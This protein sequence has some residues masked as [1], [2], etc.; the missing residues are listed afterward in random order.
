MNIL[1]YLEKLFDRREWRKEA[2]RHGS[3]YI[4]SCLQCHDMG[5]PHWSWLSGMFSVTWAWMGKHVG[6]EDSDHQCSAK[7]SSNNT[8]L[9]KHV[10]QSE[11]AV[12]LNEYNSTI[13]YFIQA[14]FVSGYLVVYIYI[15][16]WHRI[17]GWL[18]GVKS[19]PIK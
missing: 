9:L 15:Y 7:R 18:N 3:C 2:N 12:M 8:S 17:M 14:A 10:Y 19:G 13:W 11:I 6:T 4:R 1:V 16:L 5:C